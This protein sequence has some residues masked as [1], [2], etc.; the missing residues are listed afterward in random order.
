MT[1]HERLIADLRER[2][3]LA[4]LALRS[5]PKSYATFHLAVWDHPYMNT[6]QP[7]TVC[8]IRVERAAIAKGTQHANLCKTCLAAARSTEGEP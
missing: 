5:T 3:R 6:K 8:G 2:L 1:S 7:L 4:R